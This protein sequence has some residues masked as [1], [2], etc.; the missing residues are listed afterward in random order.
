MPPHLPWSLRE[1]RLE[2]EAFLRLLYAST[3]AD[4]E[5]I[6]HW[7]VAHRA[8][9][10][11]MQYEAQDRHYRDQYPCAERWIVCTRYKDIGRLILNKV[12][13]DIRIV[14]ISLL[15]VSRGKGLGSTILKTI[16]EQAD[17]LAASVSLSV[18][19]DNPARRLYQRLGFK[20]CPGG[21]PPY[22]QLRRE[23]ALERKDR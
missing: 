7:P 8:K 22:L 4:E 19:M 15:T 1:T 23:T 5:P 3:R 21:A 9:F 14:D 17:A 18:R 13:G 2:D 10:L 6:R 11:A 16:L 20:E 12:P